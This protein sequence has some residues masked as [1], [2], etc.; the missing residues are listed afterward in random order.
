MTED[1]KQPSAGPFAEQA[2][3]SIPTLLVIGAGPKA[4]A[5]GAKRHMLAKL[6]YPVPHL[7]II[8]RQGVATN[9]SG[10]AGYT[11]GSQ[12]L[13]TRP[14][15]DVGFPYLSAC[16]GDKA[17]SHAVAKEMQHLSWQSYLIDQMRYSS[18][19]DRGRTRPTHGEW[20]Q[21]I[22]WVAEKVEL[23]PCIAEV[24]TIGLTADQ[25]RWQLT[26]QPTD[27]SAPLTL[28]GDG[29]V[30]TGPGTPLTVPGQPKEHPRIIDGATFWL[31]IEEFEQ[32]RSQI[33]K[34]LNIG[35]IGT[36]E[37][38][39]A[40]V[41]AL[42]DTLRSS[43]FI[44]VISP[45]GVIYSRDEGFEEN[46]L[47]SDPDGKLAKL[48]GD[49]KHAANWLQLSERDRREFVRRTDRGVFSLKAIEEISNAENVRSVLGTV[50]RIHASDTMVRVESE[51]DGTLNHDEYDYVVVAR[52]FDALWFRHLLNDATR[53]RM[54][55]VTQ[56][57]DSKAIERSITVDLSLDGF[58]PKLHL[59]MLAGIAQ[60]PGFPNLSC[61]G[62]LADRILASYSPSGE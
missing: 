28:T 38:A 29:L 15:K 48:Y 12:F 23:A 26:C 6:G 17:L 37:T 33:T 50:R 20:S 30:I 3:E 34:P 54:Q 31:R 60:G 8:D 14:E 5:I 57:F 43:A 25:Q 44:E 40:I 4:I 24:T 59:P 58:K 22:Q 53:D 2:A 10:K 18:W 46:R 13:G 19:I 52:G 39:A 56:G 11:D 35:V 42:V 45:Y 51:Y 36:G 9:W 49:H 32:L 21:Y 27:A 1:R 47:F 55:V 62:L 61:L 7:H 16:W 41:V